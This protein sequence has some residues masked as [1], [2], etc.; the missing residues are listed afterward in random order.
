[1]V[2]RIVRLLLLTFPLAFL[3]PGTAFANT[4]NNF[5]SY[6]CAH[7]T[8]NT[9]HVGGGVASGQSVGV[10]LTSNNFNISTS[11][12]KGGSDVIVIAAFLNG[13]PSGTLNGISFTSLSSFPEGAAT[14][15]I[16]SSLQGLGLCSTT[17]NLTYG[18]VDL[19]SALATNGSVNVV[20]NGVAVGTVFYGMVLGSN[21]QIQYITPNSEAAILGKGNTVVPEPGSLTLMGTGLAGLAGLIRRKLARA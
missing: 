15:A 19:H 11:N 13:V 10:L 8:P 20:A 7:A 6:D 3:F 21:G 16:V 1:M 12:G 18:F 9:V 14:N 2:L 17:C 4:C 5:L